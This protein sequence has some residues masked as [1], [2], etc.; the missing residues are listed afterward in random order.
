MKQAFNGNIT[1][2]MAK[3]RSD[4]FIT[5][6][7]VTIKATSKIAVKK[8][9][10]YFLFLSQPLH[11]WTWITFG[12]ILTCPVLVY[13]TVLKLGSDGLKAKGGGWFWCAIGGK[14]ELFLWV[15]TTKRLFRCKGRGND[16]KSELAKFNLS[17]SYS[18][19]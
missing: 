16:D 18:K 17:N 5:I 6:A 12:I 8:W 9:H 19:L 4:I 14:F 2:D 15:W 3:W 11:S 13:D 7:L 10:F 1:G